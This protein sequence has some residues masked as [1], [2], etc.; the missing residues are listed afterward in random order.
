VKNKEQILYGFGHPN[1]KNYDPRAAIIKNLA[2]EVFS[3]TGR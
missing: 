2:E 1:Y 3:V